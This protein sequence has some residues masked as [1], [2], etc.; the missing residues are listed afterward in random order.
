[1]VSLSDLNSSSLSPI[2]PPDEESKEPHPQGLIEIE[3]LPS[4]LSQK[5]HLNDLV[6]KTK[7]ESVSDGQVKEEKKRA[8][9]VDVSQ[10]SGDHISIDLRW[11][12]LHFDNQHVE[13]EGEMN[14]YL[15][16]QQKLLKRYFVLNNRALLIYK[17]KTTYQTHT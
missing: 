11:I 5:Y 2:T 13:Y 10:N 14:K 6:P 15:I 17:D 16:H 9:I 1:M 8:Y 12:Q 4:E 3:R 7:Y